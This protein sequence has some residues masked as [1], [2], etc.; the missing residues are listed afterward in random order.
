MIDQFIIA[1]DIPWVF[2]P[3]AAVACIVVYI[4]YLVLEQVWKLFKK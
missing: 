3:V 2:I 1:K 4:G